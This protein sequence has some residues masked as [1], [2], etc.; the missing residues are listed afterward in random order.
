IVQQV[1]GATFG[2]G[3]KMSIYLNNYFRMGGEGYFSTCTYGVLKNSCRIGWGGITFDA[4]CLVKKWTPFMGVTVG[5]GSASHLIMLGYK[6]ITLS[7]LPAIF[8]KRAL[9]IVSPSMGV[10]YFA[11][12]R[13]SL[14][15]KVDYM[16]NVYKNEKSY[17]QGVRF[18]LGLHFYQKK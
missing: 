7:E 17:P 5:G 6:E 14:L 4:L 2:L 16:L 11:T 10:E 15:C 1:K 12:N 13:I 18:Y 9:V 8:L 3:G